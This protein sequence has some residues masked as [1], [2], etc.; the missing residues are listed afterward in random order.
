MVVVP[1]PK[2]PGGNPA[3][4]RQSEGCGW[5]ELASGATLVAGGVLLLAGQK[6]AGMVAAA[7]GCALALAGQQGTLKRWWEALPGCIDQVQQVLDQVQQ[8]VDEV[9]DKREK[10]VRILS[11]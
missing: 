9:A 5:L 6:K 8:T 7:S 11:R 10:L 4:P 2:T 1:I 3:G